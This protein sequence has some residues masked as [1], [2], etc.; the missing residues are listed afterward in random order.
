MKILSL[1]IISLVLSVSILVAGTYD[2]EKKA[3]KA[4][5]SVEFSVSGMTCNACVE[6]VT[7]ALKGVE[8]VNNVKVSLKE[9]KAAVELKEGA[10]TS[11]DQLVKAVTK[12]G[13]KASAGKSESAKTKKTSKNDSGCGDMDGCGGGGCDDMTTSKTTKSKQI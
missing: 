12:A 6:S 11:N 5:K 3:S 2:Q 9:G 13:Y 10:K 8:G 7:K 1:T 4:G